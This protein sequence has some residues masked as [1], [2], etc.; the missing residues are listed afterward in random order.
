MPGSRPGMTG[1]WPDLDIFGR[2]YNLN[3]SITINYR[4]PYSISN[5]LRPAASIFMAPTRRR[6]LLHPLWHVS[7]RPPTW[8]TARNNCFNPTFA[9]KPARARAGKPTAFIRVQ[10]HNFLV[11]YY[12]IHRYVVFA[13]RRMRPGERIGFPANIYS[14]VIPLL[15]PLLF[16][17][18]S[19]VNSAVISTVMGGNS[20]RKYLSQRMFSRRIFAKNG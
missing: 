16:R 12:L 13:R 6:P 5:L 1:G 18:Y 11:D 15:I 19:A 8:A 20:S 4:S 17:C 10:K 3:L 14:A 2:R 9:A 7:P